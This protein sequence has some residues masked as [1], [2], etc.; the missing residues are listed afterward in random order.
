MVCAAWCGRET[1]TVIRHTPLVR[2]RRSRIVTVTDPCRSW[3]WPSAT[4]C[5]P[6]VRLTRSVPATSADFGNVTLLG[7][8]TL[9]VRPGT[10][11]LELKLNAKQLNKLPPNRSIVLTVTATVTDAFSQTLTLSAKLTVKS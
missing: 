1:T 5:V 9:T 7:N 2:T 11:Q 10:N 4:T 3:P 8:K 6:R